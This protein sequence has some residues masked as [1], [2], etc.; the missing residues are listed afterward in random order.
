MVPG[1]AD[2]ELKLILVPVVVKKKE[3]Q[4]QLHPLAN[5]CAVR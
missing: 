1:S 4:V 3:P 2:R 5:C